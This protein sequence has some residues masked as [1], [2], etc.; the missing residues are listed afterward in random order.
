MQDVQGVSLDERK[1]GWL[2]NIACN[3]KTSA[4]KLTLEACQRFKKFANA[5]TVRNIFKKYNHG[6]VARKKKPH[7]FAKQIER[8]NYNSLKPTFKSSVFGNLL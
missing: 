8:H 1:V 4:A 2:G 3:P 6:Q 7:S 5:E